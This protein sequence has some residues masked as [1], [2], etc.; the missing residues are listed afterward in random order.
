MTTEYSQTPF[1]ATGPL[2][3]PKTLRTDQ[4]SANTVK[5]DPLIAK[6]WTYTVDIGAVFLVLA[7]LLSIGI[8]SQKFE[9]VVVMAL[10]LTAIAIASIMIV[11]L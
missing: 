9:H 6:N 3:D 8:V 11:S 7:I 2:P 5:N 10:I 4:P 1:I